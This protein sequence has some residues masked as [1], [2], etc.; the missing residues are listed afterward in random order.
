MLVRLDIGHA[1]GQIDQLDS[2]F[3]AELGD[4]R[5]E[6][7]DEIAVYHLLRPAVSAVLETDAVKYV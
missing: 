1:T 6:V 4:D 2:V 5:F 3:A 7:S